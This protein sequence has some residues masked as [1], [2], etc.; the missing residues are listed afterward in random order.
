MAIG[1][2]LFFVMNE[3]TTAVITLIF[4]RYCIIAKEIFNNFSLSLRGYHNTSMLGKYFSRPHSEI[5]FIENRNCLCTFFHQK[6][7]TAL[8]ESA[9]GRE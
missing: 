8:L 4:K 5:F 3:G 9:E 6:L 7:T 1:H 2:G